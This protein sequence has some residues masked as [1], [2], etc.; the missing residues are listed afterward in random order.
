[1]NWW[2]I[3][4]TFLA[5][6]LDFFF[7]LIFLLERYNLR[8]VIIGYLGALLVLVTISF[9][10]GK[11]LAIFLPEWIL[12]ILGILPIYMAL[13]D[14]DEDPTHAEKHGPIITTLITY[15][16]VCAGCNLSIFLPI[17][18][19]LTFQQFT[20]ALLFI[21]VLSIAIVIL[22]KGIG[23]IPLIKQTMQHYSESLMKVIYIGVGCYVF[24]DSGLI[25]HLIHLL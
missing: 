2:I 1:M 3:F 24:W 4:I 19:N 21:A 9:L 10:L 22:I 16:A 7:I 5:V 15:L 14:N 18:T 6:N 25:T 12:G 11:T 17:L 13:H 20:Q 23:N 8:D